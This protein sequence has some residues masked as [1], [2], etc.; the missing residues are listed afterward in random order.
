MYSLVCLKRTHFVP[1]RVGYCV[2]NIC[3][4]SLFCH[5]Y[6]CLYMLWVMCI[7]EMMT[8]EVCELYLRF[9]IWHN[10]ITSF[11]IV[12]IIIFQCAWLMTDSGK[13][14]TVEKAPKRITKYVCY[15]GVDWASSQWS[16]TVNVKC[17]DELCR[18]AFFML[19]FLCVWVSVFS[20]RISSLR[21][22]AF[23]SFTF[24]FYHFH[25]VCFHHNPRYRCRYLFFCLS[26]SIHFHGFFFIGSAIFFFCIYFW[27]SA[28]YTQGEW[29]LN[30]DTPMVWGISRV[31][32]T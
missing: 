1:N 3:E 8:V 2:Y 4:W 19:F 9:S 31:V 23:G 7:E 18:S 32:Q 29:A 22:F 17:S 12:I 28:R 14:R 20:F 16:P 13:E 11:V 27:V 6:W 15:F 21:F 10:T 24:L 30:V 5:C 25:V 26:L